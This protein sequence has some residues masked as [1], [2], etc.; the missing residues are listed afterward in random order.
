MLI[1]TVTQWKSQPLP[2]NHPVWRE[3]FEWIEANGATADEGIHPLSH[4]GFHARVMSYDLLGRGEAKYE[5]HRHTIDLQVTIEGVEG[6][7]YCP[8]SLLEPRGEYLAEKDFQY[9]GTPDAP[10]ARVDNHPGQFCILLPGDGHMPKLKA[11]GCSHVRK[12]V[13]K[14]PTR[15]VEGD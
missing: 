15:L 8:V 7:E 6:I 12:L 9:Y 5:A 3:A 2:Q 13:V 11:A 4:D 10:F 14:I 1:G